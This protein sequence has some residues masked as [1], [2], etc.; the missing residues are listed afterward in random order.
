MTDPSRWLVS[1]QEREQVVEFLGQALTDGRLLL[2]EYGERCAR[3]YAARTRA[4]LDEIVA[5]LPVAYAEPPTDW[6]P[7]VPPPYAPAMPAPYP[8]VPPPDRVSAVFGDETRRGRWVVPPVVEARAIFGECRVEL[9]DALFQQPYL[10]LDVLAICGRVHVVVPPGAD[11]RMSGFTVVGER[12][13]RLRHDP[14]PGAPF[15]EVR[16]YALF[17]GISVRSPSRWWQWRRGR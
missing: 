9:Q 17:G 10:V 12:Q 8:Q 13:C 6:L 3:A 15:V 1:N 16:A 4:D 14:I 11:V 5:D 7:V 2:D